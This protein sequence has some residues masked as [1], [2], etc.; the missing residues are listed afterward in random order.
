MG[1]EK[2]SMICMT[3]S[4]FKRGS[5]KERGKEEGFLFRS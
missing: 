2:I 5:L 1:I 3:Q 4:N